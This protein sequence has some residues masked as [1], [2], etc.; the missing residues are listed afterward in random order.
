[1]LRVFRL[2]FFGLPM[3][4]FVAVSL[5]VSTVLVGALAAVAWAADLSPEWFA[6]ILPLGVID[7]ASD[8]EARRQ[9]RLFN[10]AVAS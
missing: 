4:A 7:V 3:P 10:S 9:H 1:M 8:L 2:W 5:G 6:G